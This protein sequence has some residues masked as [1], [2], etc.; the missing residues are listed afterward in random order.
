MVDMSKENYKRITEH[1][2]L[3]DRLGAA[4]EIILEQEEAIREQTLQGTRDQLARI[5][6]DM[7]KI[8]QK[9]ESELSDNCKTHLDLYD[10]IQQI[11]SVPVVRDGLQRIRAV[12]PRSR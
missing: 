7:E 6:A 3:V 10:R 8:S 11:Q 5:L 1:S 12:R 4:E 9:L 2:S